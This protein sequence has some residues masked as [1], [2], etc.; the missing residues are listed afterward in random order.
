MI[1][2]KYKRNNDKIVNC[3]FLDF[4]HMVSIDLSST[5][6]SQRLRFVKYFTANQHID[7]FM[8]NKHLFIWSYVVIFCVEQGPSDLSENF[9][10]MYKLMSKKFRFMY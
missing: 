2:I 7:K 6:F 5:N 4:D 10:Q 3:K 9:I 1:V 8:K